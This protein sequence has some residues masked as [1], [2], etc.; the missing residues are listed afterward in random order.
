MWR[1]GRKMRY[2]DQK[3]AELEVIDVQ[4]AEA[5]PCEVSSL[6]LSLTEGSK[7]FRGTEC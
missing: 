1:M 3:T 6:V 7:D 4:R 5:P 2:L